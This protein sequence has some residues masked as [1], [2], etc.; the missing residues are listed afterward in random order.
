MLT[1]NSAFLGSVDNNDSIL[2]YDNYTVPVALRNNH[3][4]EFL[5]YIGKY[6]SEDEIDTMLS[7]IK[8]RASYLNEDVSLGLKGYIKNLVSTRHFSEDFLVKYYDYLSREDILIMHAS[9]IATNTYPELALLLMAD[10]KK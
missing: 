1:T 5:A 6:L 8:H 7:N 4:N 2:I 9:E 10:D 3:S